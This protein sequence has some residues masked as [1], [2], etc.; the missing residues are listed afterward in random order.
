MAICIP[1]RVQTVSNGHNLVNFLWQLS[2]WN[3]RDARNHFRGHIWRK[4]AKRAGKCFHQIRSVYRPFFSAPKPFAAKAKMLLFNP[5]EV[6]FFA[7]RP[8]RW[9]LA[10]EV[11]SSSSRASQ[12][13]KQTKLQLIDQRTSAASLSTVWTLLRPTVHCFHKFFDFSYESAPICCRCPVSIFRHICGCVSCAFRASAPS[14][15]QSA[16][17]DTEGDHSGD[18]AGRNCCHAAFSSGLTP[19]CKGSDLCN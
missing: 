8:R 12:I 7:L 17:R 14:A 11:G 1:R 10:S 15:V 13:E 9:R 5:P 19:F 6:S 18:G 4:N 3:L 2:R 16:S